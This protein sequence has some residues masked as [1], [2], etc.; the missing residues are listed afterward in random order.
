M[1][2]YQK[3]KDMPGPNRPW[4]D[5]RD[6]KKRRGWK[7][8]FA[9][10]CYCNPTGPER[11]NPFFK[12]QRGWRLLDIKQFKNMAAVMASHSYQQLY[13]PFDHRNHLVVVARTKTFAEYI[14]EF[15]ING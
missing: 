4:P 12:G 9:V 15:M 2:N 14:T 1:S 6:L 8:E 7:R 10:L 3:F 13:S 5:P 11:A